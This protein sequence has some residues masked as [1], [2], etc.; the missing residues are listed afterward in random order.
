MYHTKPYFDCIHVKSTWLL[1]LL[2]MH[3]SICTP[4]YITYSAYHIVHTCSSNSTVCMIST[5]I[6]LQVICRIPH[7]SWLYIPLANNTTC[8]LYPKY[9]FPG[10]LE[11]LYVRTNNSVE[12]SNNAAIIPNN[13]WFE[14]EIVWSDIKQEINWYS[15]GRTHML[16]ILYV[17]LNGVASRKYFSGNEMKLWGR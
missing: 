1:V 11:L 5:L 8:C 14:I 6:E 2:L 10:L 12:R 15:I 13:I 9:H 16:E 17:I 4:P 7:H 3:I